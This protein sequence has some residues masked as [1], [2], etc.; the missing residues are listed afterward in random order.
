MG[1]QDK[2]PRWI[3]SRPALFILEQVFALEKF[4]TMLMRTRLATDL[5]VT[6]RQVQ[7]WFQNRRQRE[8]NLRKQGLLDDSPAQSSNSLNS[9]DPADLAFDAAAPPPLLTFAD[10]DDATSGFLST[11]DQIMQ[12][13]EARDGTPP[14]PAPPPR[15][16]S[17]S[18]PPSPPPRPPPPPPSS[19]PLLPPAR[20]PLPLLPRADPPRSNASDTSSGLDLASAPSSPPARLAGG[21][22]GGMSGM[23]HPLDGGTPAG[24][25]SSPPHVADAGAPLCRRRTPACRRR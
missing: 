11:P 18:P 10:R 6:P 16:P 20:H 21:A 3:V 8:R 24:A 14:A 23:P 13:L 1:N 7:I 25:S 19:P 4:P 9:S 15:P 17:P 12:A 5:G 2:A 22:V